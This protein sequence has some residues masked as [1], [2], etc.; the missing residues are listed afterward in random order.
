MVHVEAQGLGYHHSQITMQAVK[1][2]PENL[3]L[4]NRD[5]IVPKQIIDN[6]LAVFISDSYILYKLHHV[7]I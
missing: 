4:K 3:V 5:N 1:V 7:R 6:S 2:Q